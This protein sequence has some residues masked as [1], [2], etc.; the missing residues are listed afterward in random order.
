MAPGK[1]KTNVPPASGNFQLSFVFVL[2][3]EHLIFAHTLLGASLFLELQFD[4]S[5][6]QLLL[7]VLENGVGTI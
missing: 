5:I 7:S 6:V 3:Y 4:R 2:E 1:G